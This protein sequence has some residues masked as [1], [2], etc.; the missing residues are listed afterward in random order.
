APFGLGNP[1][2]T[3]LAESCELAELAPVGD[4]RHLRFRVRSRRG[5]A[6]SAIAFGLGAQLDRYRRI[7]R[8][9]LVFRLQ[10]NEWNGTVAPQLVVTRIFD[11]PE[12]YERLRTWLAAE[13]RKDG[14]R[15]PLAPDPFP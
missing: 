2:V 13:Y 3:L 10:A 5:D 11:T 1:A 14:D 7:G 9:D 8:Y 12:T 4:G 6:G 15:D